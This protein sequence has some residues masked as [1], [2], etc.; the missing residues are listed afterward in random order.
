MKRLNIATIVAAS[1]ALAACD[2][3]AR[4]PDG[5]T[6][7]T[8]SETPE[9]VASEVAEPVLEGI[10]KQGKVEFLKCRSC[11]TINEG[12]IHLTGPNLHGLIG[13]TAGQKEGYVFSDA[14]VSSELVWTEENLDKW[15]ENPSALVEGN[16]MVFAGVPDG[17]DRAALIAYLKVVTE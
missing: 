3:G 15:I 9:V 16:K 7:G 12:D 13:A 8:S 10:A 4:A 5:D 14:L 11:H 1:A 6:S 17:E 2:S